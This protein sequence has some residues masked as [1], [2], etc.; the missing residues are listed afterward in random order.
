MQAWPVSALRS[1][2]KRR[3]RFRGTIII[4][5]CCVSL[6]GLFIGRRFTFGQDS[7]ESTKIKVDAATRATPHRLAAPL[8]ITDI[9][10]Y[11]ALHFD[12]TR[13]D[14]GILSYELSKTAWIRIRIVSRRD[15]NLVLAT[16]ADWTKRDLGTN[17]EKWNGRDASGYWINQDQ[18]PC[19]F[20]IDGDSPEHAAHD[21]DKCCDMPLQIAAPR[22]DTSIR[23]K[24]GIRSAFTE[25]KRPYGVGAHTILR[26][27]VDYTLNQEQICDLSGSESFECVWDSTCVANG[28]HMLTVNLDDGYDHMASAS[29][30]IEVRN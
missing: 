18:C 5:A 21:K 27:Y 15:S 28:P 25:N 7:I 11:E 24:V 2:H 23:G 3:L 9:S 22:P 8:E 6:C 17:I 12:R 20:T 1:N 29:V 30:R 10:T 14:Y 4:L 26:L 19:I 16:L 13:Q